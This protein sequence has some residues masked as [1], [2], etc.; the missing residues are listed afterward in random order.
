MLHTEKKKS[1]KH[2]LIKVSDPINLKNYVTKNIKDK[3]SDIY[4]NGKKIKGSNNEVLNVVY[5]KKL[6]LINEQ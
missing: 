4:I 5:K 6:N 1:Y 3:K 2:G